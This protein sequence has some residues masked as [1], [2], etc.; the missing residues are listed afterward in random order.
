MKRQ[1]I[2]ACALAG[3]VAA[4]AIGGGVW[5]TAHCNTEN[6]AAEAAV[7]SIERDGMQAW[8]FDKA[9]EMLGNELGVLEFSDEVPGSV[10]EA[11]R[12]A[13]ARRASRAWCALYNGYR[14]AANAGLR[15]EEQDDL[16]LYYTTEGQELDLCFNT[17]SADDYEY[18]DEYP[19]LYQLIRRAGE[20]KTVTLETGHGVSEYEQHVSVAI[21][22][23]QEAQLL[24]QQ[25]QE[26]GTLR[27]A[28]PR[29][30]A[31]LTQ[32]AD[33]A[34]SAEQLGPLADATPEQTAEL[35]RR[36][37]ETERAL[38]SAVSTQRE[39]KNSPQEQARCGLL[40]LAELLGTMK[41]TLIAEMK[42][43]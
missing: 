36:Y 14:R 21:R 6:P 43:C 10:A 17:L 28:L 24:V 2:L 34:C 4:T 7:R 23:V 25:S 8:L 40:A 26:S 39:A 9:R 5:Y 27:E 16:D 31:I 30:G 32:A 38:R 29:L 20:W 3:V 37:E 12:F 22:L 42:G 15:E 19:L 13:Q 11:E 41:A 18:R 1:H 33:N 35:I